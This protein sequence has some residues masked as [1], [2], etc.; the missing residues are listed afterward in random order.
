MMFI[1]TIQRDRLDD[2][3]LLKVLSL[4]VLNATF[5]KFQFNRG[6]QFYWWRKPEKTTNLL[7]VANKLYCI[8]LYGVHLA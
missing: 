2:Q 1:F 7:Q 6:S 3:Q 8:M 5:N 4:M